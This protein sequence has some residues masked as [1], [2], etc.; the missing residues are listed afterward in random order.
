MDF[1]I[2]VVSPWLGIVNWVVVLILF[3]IDLTLVS[4]WNQATIVL[5]V[6]SVILAIVLKYLSK[7]QGVVGEYKHTH[8]R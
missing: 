5:V 7:L 8:K 4:F 2:R 6:S 1:I 3:M